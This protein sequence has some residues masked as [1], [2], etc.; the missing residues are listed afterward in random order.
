VL[1][2]N[3]APYH[4]AV[5]VLHVIGLALLALIGIYAF[6]R[7]TGASYPFVSGLLGLSVF[8]VFPVI[9]QADWSNLPIVFQNYM[10]ME[11]GSTFTILPWLGY[12][13]I[14]GVIG[15]V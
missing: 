14:G 11:N 6:H 2:L 5:D 4:I 7:V 9:E 1:S 10:T 8:L 13:L 15:S 3:F 12:T